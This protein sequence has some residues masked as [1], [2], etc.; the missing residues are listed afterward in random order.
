MRVTSRPVLIDVGVTPGATRV[1]NEGPYTVSYGTDQT[2]ATALDSIPA[3]GQV[4]I[5]GPRWFATTG[6]QTTNLKVLDVA[7]V[8]SDIQTL[9]QMVAYLLTVSTDSRGETYPNGLR[10]WIR[11]TRPHGAA[12]MPG[13]VE[14]YIGQSE[15]AAPGAPAQETETSDE[16]SDDVWFNTTSSSLALLF[17]ANYALYTDKRPDLVTATE[18]FGQSLMRYQWVGTPTSTDAFL[19]RGSFMLTASD[20]RA[21]SF[22]TGLAVRA[23]LQAYK[24]T[25]NPDFLNSAIAGADFLVRMSDPNTYWGAASPNGYSVSP[26]NRLTSSITWYGFCDRIDST[27]KVSTY[28]SSWN[29]VAARAL[30][31]L[32]AFIGQTSYVT[33]ATQARDFMASQILNGYDYFAVST[34]AGTYASAAWSLS[35]SHTFND[36][37]KHRLGDVLSVGTVGTDQIEYGLPCLYSMGYDSEAIR[38]AYKTF[39]DLPHS[40]AKLVGPPADSTYS[41]ENSDSGAFG[42][43]YNGRICWTGYFR[44]GTF[45]TNSKVDRA[46]GTYYDAQGACTLGPYKAKEHPEDFELSHRLLIE[47]VVRGSL[48]QS[49][50]STKWSSGSTTDTTKRGAIVVASAAEALLANIE[51]RV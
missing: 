28:C 49:D 10:R 21:T 47:T 44:L 20:S 34:N 3:N 1:V 51:G 41:S 45:G 13:P 11:L 7:P 26:I 8:G 32:G 12:L 5:S 9:E 15:D 39:R 24:A 30:Y 22:G 31:E 36:H 33:V 19:R 23:L 48:L 35:S 16:D 50:L 18:R 25:G 38:T 6:S 27:D 37:A 42:A 43:A 17:L 40:G 46:Y 29:I 14:A 4:L 2:M